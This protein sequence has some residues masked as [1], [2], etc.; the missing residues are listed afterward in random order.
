[1][2]SPLNCTPVQISASGNVR[3]ASCN[4]AGIFVSA[5]SGTPTITI[6]DD[7]ASGTTKKVVDTFPVVAGQWYPL[8]FLFL[9]GIN[10]V[11]GGTVSA[12]VAVA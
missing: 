4:L 10:I 1:M 6:Y 5:A 3:A 11:L 7:V 9:N 8:P 12:T 2:S